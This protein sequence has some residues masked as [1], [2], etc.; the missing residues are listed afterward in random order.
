[1]STQT[2]GATGLVKTFGKTDKSDP[3]SHFL[4]NIDKPPMQVNGAEFDVIRG[5]LEGD[6]SISSEVK[7]VLSILMLGAAKGLNISITELIQVS[8]LN[9][10]KI[11]IPELGLD[12]INK[13]R[14]VTSQIGIKTVNA[15]AS[16]V[17]YINRNIIS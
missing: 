10:G 17:A 7:N 5:L 11:S 2:T 1:M 15:D 6:Q 9:P 16:D 8:K 12:I 14:P 4:S 3:G 13:L